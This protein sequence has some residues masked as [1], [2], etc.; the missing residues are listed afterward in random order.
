M[1]TLRKAEE[2]GY[3]SHDWLDSHFSFSFAEYFDPAHVHFGSLRVLNDDI[4]QPDSGFGMHPHSD[5][6]ILTYILEGTLS[7]RDSM[8]HGED[9]H[10]GEV[11]L[12][13]AG[14]G[15]THSEFNAS[16][17]HPVHLLQIWIMP[18]EQGL[19]PTYRQK[20]FPDEAKRGKWCLI[21]SP[22]ATGGSLR[23][24]Q[25]A[26]VFAAL[27]HGSETL[28]YAVDPSRKV[29]LHVARG[30]LTA[31]GQSLSGGDALMYSHEAKV[32]LT[33]GNNA[34]VLLFDLG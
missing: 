20:A 31:N 9:L 23:I 26:R 5:M 1:I 12:M 13:S 29:Y 33:G 24:H 14:S 11:Q 19:A 17:I 10:Q 22:D 30:S 34:E 16:P 18:D 3:A 32:S 15:V 6:E 27:L 4:I 21:A 28:D 2:R 8:G 7:H 25:D